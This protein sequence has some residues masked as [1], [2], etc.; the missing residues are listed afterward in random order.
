M[1]A[2]LE[3]TALGM[4]S[5]LVAEGHIGLKM[6]AADCSFEVAVESAVIEASM[7]VNT[8]VQRVQERNDSVERLQLEAGCTAMALLLL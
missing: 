6:A 3:N 4:V 8:V 7:V 1:A 5:E 2:V